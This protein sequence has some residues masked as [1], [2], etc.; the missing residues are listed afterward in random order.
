M[1]H[2]RLAIEASSNG[3]TFKNIAIGV[4]LPDGS[5]EFPA[6][7]DAESLPTE[8]LDALQRHLE[9]VQQ[10]VG[11]WRHKLGNTVYQ[12]SF[13]TSPNSFT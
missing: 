1:Q 10:N 8:L 9:T 4:R 12:V 5:L 6:V 3:E 11:S 7:E 2:L 13:K